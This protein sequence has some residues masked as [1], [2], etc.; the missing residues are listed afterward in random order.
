MTK[1]QTR[2]PKRHVGGTTKWD[3]SK[4]KLPGNYKGSGEAGPS[5]SK[6]PP[7]QTESVASNVYE[8][9]N[10][11][12]YWTPVVPPSCKLFVK[13]RF[14]S[15]EAA[16][17]MY[18]EYAQLA[19]FCTRLGTSKKEKIGDK[20]IT[21]LRYVLCSRAN[22]PKDTD[23][24]PS[25]VDTISPKRR[26]NIKVTDCK[27]C[28]K[29]KRVKDTDEVELYKWVEQHNHGFTSPENLDLSLKKRKHDFSTTEF[30]AKCRNANI[31]PMKSHKLQ[32]VIKGGHHNVQG[33]VVD[34]KNCGR[35]I[36]D[37][38][39]KRDAQMLVDKMN[40][41]CKNKENY[42]FDTQIVDTELQLIFWCD[43][44]SKMNYEAFGD[45]LAFDATYHTNM[46]DM[47]FVP[48][49]GVD[50]HK[51]CMIFGAGLLH[52]ET[53][54]SYTWLLQKF[55]QAHNGRQPLLVL[56]D[57]DCAMKQ[58][59]GDNLTNI[60]IK[61]KFHKLVW[62]VY[63]KPET[64]EQRWNSLITE[65]GLESHK[66]LTEMFSIREQWIPG[67][68]REIPMSTL[69]K[70]T[71]RC[72]S[73][74]HMFKADSSAHNTLVQFML[75]YDTSI[76]GLRNKQR[77]VCN[78]TETTNPEKF[79][80][81]YRIERHANVVYTR[82]IFYEVQKQIFNGTEFRYIAER[83]LVDGVHCFTVAHLDHEKEVVNEFKV[84]QLSLLTNIIT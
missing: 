82:K 69:M 68:F 80:T 61:E 9:P 54:E 77:E 3:T 55:L 1:T 10:G 25:E 70:T 2:N 32:V 36:R 6:D 35:D 7:T 75:C 37:F 56:T 23:G 44:V 20:V 31:G 66:W 62:N 39:D 63:I 12:R 81:S 57:Q 43:N 11:S 67:Y 74:K 49:T 64:F 48:F 34:Y 4:V 45:V 17:A 14:S 15:M 58:I 51:K 52:N 65:Y 84:S 13:A 71:S 30:I 18:E 53:I 29:F 5:G 28:V 26:S 83:S 24:Q 19:G 40:A 16:I 33:T 73:A 50:H 46:Y 38:I 78:H 76:D 47:I 8:T 79:K 42:T 27:A 72:E 21:N 22:K 60:E 59:K 41:R